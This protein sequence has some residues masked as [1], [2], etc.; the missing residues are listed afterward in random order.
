MAKH[1]IYGGGGIR[2]FID[3]WLLKEKMVIDYD[4]LYEMLQETKLI[5]FYN[6]ASTL[7]DVWMLGHK[8]NSITDQMELFI[9]KGGVYG[10]ATNSATVKAAKGESKIRS[11]SN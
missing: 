5:D 1:F 9:F 2:P 3:L 4:L 6:S 11:F 8:H 7:A 10:S